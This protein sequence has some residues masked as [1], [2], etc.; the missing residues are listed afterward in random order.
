MSKN[1]FYRCE[2][3][4]VKRLF[5]VQFHTEACN[6]VLQQSILSNKSRPSYLLEQYFATIFDLWKYPLQNGSDDKRV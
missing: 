3:N 6:A 4:S 1:T 5:R 2:E